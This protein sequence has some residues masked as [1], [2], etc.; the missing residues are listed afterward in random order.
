MRKSIIYGILLVIGGIGL[1]SYYTDGIGSKTPKLEGEISISDLMSAR[2]VN[3]ESQG[4][5]YNGED[6]ELSQRVICTDRNCVTELLDLDKESL[7]KRYLRG[8][9]GYS[10]SP[11]TNRFYYE[12]DKRYLIKQAE[13]G[14]WDAIDILLYRLDPVLAEAWNGAIKSSSLGEEKK[15][16]FVNDK[17]KYSD[18]YIE[19]IERRMQAYH[20]IALI[21]AAYGRT[22]VLKELNAREWTGK[23][24][25][26]SSMLAAAY[27]GD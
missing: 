22:S 1:F 16:N 11:D 17:Q 19:D 13:L 3:A 25:Y 21:A 26:F 15:Q 2:L 27:D 10:I 24:N 23:K 9:F 5:L 6:T 14:D 20:D 12:T 8:H 18:F 7:T 4:K